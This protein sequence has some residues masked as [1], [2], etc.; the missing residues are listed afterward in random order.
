MDYI[1]KFYWHPSLVIFTVSCRQIVSFFPSGC[2]YSPPS[3]SP[4]PRFSPRYLLRP[5]GFVCLLVE[6]SSFHFFFS[7]V[8]WW[9]PSVLMAIGGRKWRSV[10]RTK[11]RVTSSSRRWLGKAFVNE[12]ERQRAYTNCVMQNINGGASRIDFAL[13][14]SEP[15]KE[16]KKE[17]KSTWDIHPI[18]LHLAHIFFQIII[19]KMLSCS[20]KIGIAQY[21]PEHKRVNDVSLIQNYRDSKPETLFWKFKKKV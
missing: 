20:R 15:Q 12:G 1:L 3:H 18:L 10:I 4:P 8:S 7:F 17:K 14:L 11:A 16:R 2:L 9:S 6:Y 19:E 5:K 13:G 21:A